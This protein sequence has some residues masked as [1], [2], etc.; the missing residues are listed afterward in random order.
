MADEAFALSPISARA[1]LPTEQDYE[2]I[3][4]AFMETSRGRWFLGEYAKRNRNAD[5]RMVLEAVGRIEQTI[6]AQKQPGPESGLS[7]ALT[8]IRLAVEQAQA[9]AATALESSALADNLAP[10]HKAARIIK[11]ISWRWREIGADSRICD[12][13]DSQ[14]SAIESACA[15]ISSRRPHEG[16]AAAFDLI[17]ARIVQLEDRDTPMSREA[18]RT[19]PSAFPAVA[20]DGVFTAA[21]QTAP[22]MPARSHSADTFKKAAEPV[23]ETV[24]VRARKNWMATA[25]VA[26]LI[27]EVAEGAAEPVDALNEAEAESSETVEPYDDSLL[28]LVA[29]EMSA[30][31]FLD[32]DQVPD[33]MQATEPP[34]PEPIVVVIQ[35][36]EPVV[37]IQNAEP[38]AVLQEQEKAPLPAPQASTASPG[39]SPSLGSTLL[40]NGVVQRPKPAGSDPL[41]P[42]RRM[43]QAEKIAFFS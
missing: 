36:P 4:Q 19:A 10:V 23:L 39:S 33:D 20:P 28:D 16:L 35:K 13:L 40:A 26:G 14:V 12:L 34:A 9:A 8:S 6:A 24:E 30:P 5:T 41:A 38:V 21:E 2:A 25:K 27:P 11:E 37:V 17:R 42:I 31:E 22:K 15:Q 29:Q 3:S 18:G 7:D 32:I 1:V 43:S